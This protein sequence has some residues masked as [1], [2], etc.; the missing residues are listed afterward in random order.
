MRV[1]SVVRKATSSKSVE[2]V[3]ARRSLSATL[4]LDSSGV[5]LSAIEITAGENTFRVPKLLVCGYV[6]TVE[7]SDPTSHPGSSPGGS[8]S[9]V[10]NLPH[11]V[12]RDVCDLMD[13]TLNCFLNDTEF[14]RKLD[15]LVAE[16]ERLRLDRKELTC[17]KFLVLFNPAKH[18]MNIGSDWTV[19][20]LP[21][22]PDFNFFSWLPQY[23]VLESSHQHV[24]RVQGKLSR[25]LL[26]RSRR[27]TR[28]SAFQSPLDTT[29]LSSTAQWPSSG[30]P[31]R[32][33][34]PKT[35]DNSTTSR[36]SRVLL[37][38]S[39]VKYL[40]FQIESYLLTRY[41]NGKIPQESLLIE[42]LLNKRC[43]PQFTAHSSSTTSY[44]QMS[45][46]SM[47]VI[48]VSGH[49]NNAYHPGS[50]TSLNCPTDMKP[51]PTAATTSFS[52]FDESINPTSVLS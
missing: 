40:A 39:E 41:R 5:K 20:M 17:L 7:P 14:R 47:N 34:E 16:F 15:D 36:F 26:R 11:S 31:Q 22:L 42:M 13:S 48:S 38:L 30:A 27:S 21:D 52:Q 1:N 2:I 50:I 49:S 29:E 24:L 10:S 44:G 18:G 51:T 33:V 9:R 43:R 25:F 37:Q 3:E 35:W 45:E 4:A 46:L 23:L 28:P 6:N 12:S 8:S 19:V 32:E